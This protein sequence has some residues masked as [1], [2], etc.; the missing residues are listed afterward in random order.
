MSEPQPQAAWACDSPDGNC[1][2]SHRP[3]TLLQVS[4]SCT[5]CVKG[6]KQLAL[7]KGQM[8]CFTLKAPT[9]AAV[10]FTDTGSGR[11]P[12]ILTSDLRGELRW[13]NRILNFYSIKWYTWLFNPLLPTRQ[14]YLIH[15]RKKCQ[16]LV[17]F[18]LPS[19]SDLKILI[20]DKWTGQDCTN[21]SV[22]AEWHK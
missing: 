1:H 10:V 11:L 22:T 14:D 7:Y 16:D 13:F 21:F 5:P 20:N 19:I 2:Y 4:Q 12:L 8:W 17:W 18:Y 6:R 3:G 15:Y 9:T